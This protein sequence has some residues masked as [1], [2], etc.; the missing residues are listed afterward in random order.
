MYTNIPLGPLTLPT[1]PILALIAVWIGLDAMGRYGK[2]WR[3]SI[4]DLWNLS[5]FAL[6]AGLI[7]ARLWNVVQFWPV[8]VDQPLMIFS[9]RPGGFEFWP[10]VI[11]AGVVGYAYLIWRSLDPV[12][13]AAALAFG[14]V[15]AGSILS[16]SAYLTGAVV[17]VAT[18]LPWGVNYFG[19]A[20]HA[21][22]LYQA[23][24]L[25]I[26]LVDLRGHLWSRGNRGKRIIDP[27]D[28]PVQAAL[29]PSP[30]AGDSCDEYESGDDE[31]DE[32]LPSSRHPLAG[33][34]LVRGSDLCFHH[35]SFSAIITS[36]WRLLS[37]LTRGAPK[38]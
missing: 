3:L 33:S 18:E 21:V 11:A 10:G 23:V 13:V 14:L 26:L 27:V 12:T 22:G 28:H 34:G 1:G 2:R 29:H 5:L 19:K 17:G 9:V 20:V 35:E 24:G 38:W 4:D 25:L 36:D 31:E 6:T 30:E 16:A 32:S 7:V 37:R 8:Y 15:A